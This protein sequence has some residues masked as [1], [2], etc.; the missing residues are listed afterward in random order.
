M[1]FKRPLLVLFLICAIMSASSF[2]YSQSLSYEYLLELG[3]E[4]FK[5]ES[6]DEA[7]HYFNL[8]QII[9]PASEEVNHYVNLI[10][11]IK[12]GRVISEKEVTDLEKFIKKKKRKK[13]LD[14]EI[15][16]ETIGKRKI[17][18]KQIQRE[19]P[20]KKRDQR[21]EKTLDLLE[22]EETPSVA[23]KTTKSPDKKVIK[24]KTERK[25]DLSLASE[26]DF[27]LNIQI[28]RYNSF[29][30]TSGRIKNF[31]VITPEVAFIEK[32]D[33][34]SL[35]VIAERTGS[36]F[37]HVW[38]NQRRW[39]FNL[40]VVRPKI[41]AEAEKGWE[42]P[43][44][45]DFL[46]AIDWDGYYQ[47]DKFRT[48][49][50]KTL[51]VTQW[52]GIRG[53]TPYGELYGFAHWEKF[54]SEHELTGYGISL[55]EGKFMNFEDFSL[56]GFDFNQYFSPLSF[57]GTTLRGIA[58]ESPAFNK[59]LKYTIF[60]GR[61][62]ETYYHYISPG[63]GITHD[64]DSFATGYS[65]TL[66][67]EGD[68]KFTFNHAQAYGRDRADYLKEKVYSVETEHNIDNLIIRTET[69]TDED[70]VA[71][72]I[73]SSITT[74]TTDL[75]LSFRNIEKDF[76]T[77]AGRP[78]DRGEIGGII[79]FNW[80]PSDIFTARTN[81]DIYKERYLPNPDEPDKINFN[82]H[83]SLHLKLTPKSSLRSYLNYSY[84]PGIISP[85]RTLNTNLYYNKQFTVNFFGEHYLS[86]YLGHAFQ[87]SINSLSPTADY[88]RH[89]VLSG[90]RLEL[91]PDLYSYCD[92][93]Y[94]WVTELEDKSKSN[95]AVF[96]AGLDYFRSLTPS[97]SFNAR[98]NYRNEEDTTAVHSFL[99]GED[100]LEGSLNISFFP[101]ENTELFL[102]GR[103]RNV[104][105][106]D[107]A[108][109]EYVEADIRL[110][111]RLAW[112]NF[113]IWAAKTKIKG[114]V[115]EDKNGN[116][117]KDK[118]EKGIEGI[119]ITIGPKKVK[120]N[121]D[122]EFS[123]SLKAK[124][125]IAS[126]DLRDVPSKYVLT[127][128]G[129]YKLDISK[130]GTKKIDFGLSSQSS[131][132][133]VVYY[134]LNNNN[135]LDEED[136]PIPKVKVKL[137]KEQETTTNGEGVYYFGNLNPGRH[138]VILDVNSLPIEYIPKVSI[139]KEIK[140]PQGHTYNYNIPLEKK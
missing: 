109:Q 137:N 45:L 33:Q 40:N 111:A 127:T 8:A 43:E 2:S 25:I 18:D 100:S 112:E 91:I 56:Y 121:Q 115:F 120:T 65:L 5:K 61:E 84:V 3:K 101:T 81:L 125:V 76:V 133:G 58:F 46:Y 94:S 124:S 99:S 87:R 20:K 59:K 116:Q 77:I 126:I 96:T 110:G 15:P 16:R 138:K 119:T 98:L 66:F 62:G 90:I 52:A 122:G 86:T 135:K 49:E 71:A 32:I 78:P 139:T 7:L 113:F 69:A 128:S 105:A 48:M 47:G 74:P 97:L 37:I 22:K 79:D 85:Y 103:V 130:G 95:P 89:S 54:G 83:N 70:S 42:K 92:Y 136:N 67:P 19:E 75:N 1:H 50:R 64:K 80:R 117:T 129:S 31:L 134:D 114:F 51:N 57:P 93:T 27:P 53:P 23:A 108:A 4:E 11:R 14:E 9:N 106:E 17:K 63:I 72:T 38:D 29:L 10:K 26:D 13:K 55:T 107:P 44:G 6:Y 131:I 104:W 140:V 82:L 118:D 132:Y 102:D 30:I 68:H 73:S 60:H 35:K 88:K 24:E 12:E 123:A 36:T 21:I 34:S 28:D 41:Y 39:T